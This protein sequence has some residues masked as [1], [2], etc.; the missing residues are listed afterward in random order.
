[1]ITVGLTG[2]IGSGKSAVG[3]IFELLGI[4]VYSSDRAARQLMENDPY[5]KSEITNLL[6]VKSYDNEQLNRKYIAS[7]VF[8]NEVLLAKLNAIVHPAVY[9]DFKIWISNQKAPYVVKES[10]LLLDTLRQQPVDQIITVFAPR[11]IRI[12][13]IMKRDCLS[14]EETT[15]RMSL[16][17]SDKEFLDN[18][19]YVIVNDNIHSL[20][21]QVLSI[22]TELINFAYSI[23]K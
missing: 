22:H 8:E 19:D 14:F 7:L 12:E 4:P 6:G 17:R 15:K 5:I 18:S 13:R 9:E 16:Q 2:G 1:M 11:E 23:K 10:A 20:S 21:L 3:F